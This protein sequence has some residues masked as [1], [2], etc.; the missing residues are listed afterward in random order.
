VDSRRMNVS[1]SHASVMNRRSSASVTPAFATLHLDL[2]IYLPRLKVTSAIPPALAVDSRWMNLS[3]RKSTSLLP[4][5]ILDSICKNLILDVE[6]WHISN[7]FIIPG[8]ITWQ[9]C[10][11]R[12]WMF[13]PRRT[14][15]TSMRR[16]AWIRRD[17]D[18]EWGRI[19]FGIHSTCRHHS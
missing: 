2:Q 4:A 7:L 16:L 13:E 5:P 9:K 11:R 15:S 19:S 6:F 3:G 17:I 10:C 1:A 12:C 14:L 18:L 8:M